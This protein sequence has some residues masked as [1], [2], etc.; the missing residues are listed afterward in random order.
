MAKSHGVRMA[1]HIRCVF[2]SEDVMIYRQ[3]YEFYYQFVGTGFHKQ[4]S[5]QGVYNKAD[6]NIRIFRWTIQ[7]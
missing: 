6:T 2:N 5:G 3:D 1:D 7:G 4:T